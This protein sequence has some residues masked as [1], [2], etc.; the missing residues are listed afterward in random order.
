M[1]TVMHQGNILF[2]NAGIPRIVDFGV[3]SMTF[4]DRSNNDNASIPWRGFSLRWAAPEIQEAPP[5]G[6]ARQPTKMSDIYAFGMVVVEVCYH[7]SPSTCSLTSPSDFYREIS[8][9]R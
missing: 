5:N 3:S 6:E 8:F 1:L 9:P 7:F 4:D 2:D